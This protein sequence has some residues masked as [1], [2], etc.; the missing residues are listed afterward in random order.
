MAYK[1][2]KRHG[3]RKPRGN[4]RRRYRK[5]KST[6]GRVMRQN[7]LYVKA[8]SPFYYQPGATSPNPVIAIAPGTNFTTGFMQFSY[9][10]NTFTE[11]V[12]AFCHA[13]EEVRINCVVVTVRPNKTVLDS[14]AGSGGTSPP[15]VPQLFLARKKV[16]P[17]TTT[18]LETVRGDDDVK[19]KYLDKNISCKIYH[20][21]IQNNFVQEVSP[22]LSCRDIADQ[23][24]P[25]N[26]YPH[27]GCAYLIRCQN[28]I[29]GATAAEFSVFAEYYLE[30]R[31]AG[32]NF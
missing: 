21:T 25:V 11:H 1:R 7:H 29:Q 8:I 4:V 23:T 20:P 16:I 32:V 9:D 31:N 5:T 15:L 24:P 14:M 30:F 12:R 17:Q 22:W 28:S 18:S 26:I 2:Y 6:L 3:Y 19:M 27:N 13:F 10:Q